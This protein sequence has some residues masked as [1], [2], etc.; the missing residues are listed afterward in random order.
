MFVDKGFKGG[1]EIPRLEVLGVFGFWTPVICCRLF[2]MAVP[3]KSNVKV[4][5]SLIWAGFEMDFNI[6][7]LYSVLLYF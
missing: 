3:S 4:W 5:K 7:G 2:K 6:V 1:S